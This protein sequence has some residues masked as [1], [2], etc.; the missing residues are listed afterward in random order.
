LERVLTRSECVP[1]PPSSG[2]AGVL[3][4]VAG[5][6]KSDALTKL[7]LVTRIEAGPQH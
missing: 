6:R 3:V 2:G 4:T 7:D 5:F 1:D